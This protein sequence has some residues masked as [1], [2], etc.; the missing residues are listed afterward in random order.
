MQSKSIKQTNSKSAHTLPAVIVIITGIISGWATHAAIDATVQ[1]FSRNTIFLCIGFC[2]FYAIAFYLLDL[3]PRFIDVLIESLNLR[4]RRKLNVSA[5]F[6]FELNWQSVLTGAFIILLL[7]SPWI[8]LHHSGYL[9]SDTYNQL[10]QWLGGDTSWQQRPG[11]SDHHPVF[12]TL[13][14][15]VIFSS[16]KALT[17]QYQIG[18]VCFVI[19]KVIYMSVLYSFMLNYAHK[20]WRVCKRYTA[21]VLLVV[22][23]CPIFPTALLTVVKDSLFLLFIIPW[24]FMYIEGI[25]TKWAVLKSIPFDLAF[26]LLAVFSCLARQTS[27]IIIPVSLIAAICIRGVTPLRRIIALTAVFITLFSSVILFPALTDKPLRVVHEG[28]EQLFVVPLQL[29]ARVA[30]DHG[31]EIS[32]SDKQ[33]ITRLNSHSFEQMQKNYSPYFVDPVA[34]MR[35]N[36]STALGPYLKLWVRQGLRY[37]DSYFNGFVS[38]H[39][40]WFAYSKPPTNAIRGVG[41]HNIVPHTATLY[42]RAQKA[43][44]NTLRKGGDARK[45]LNLSEGKN[46]ETTQY[47]WDIITTIQTPLV[48]QAFWTWFL[49]MFIIY[50]LVKRRRLYKHFVGLI[51]YFL[52]LL[53]LLAMSITLSRYLFAIV[54][55]T[56]IIALFILGK[57]F[58]EESD[59][60]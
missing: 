18:F 44:A 30:Y 58:T 27:L 43:T 39:S 21:L 40:G 26:I 59:K 25:R 51:P 37:P 1:P 53:S 54:F 4:E 48:F 10:L 50:A 8:Y 57:S 49:P 11:I 12:T 14:Y 29:T 6:L 23:I 17:G 35:F 45:M 55:L 34:Q 36:D 33:L 16:S 24:V 52:S 2:I 60:E 46:I 5:R 22:G 13:I 9:A 42:R 47:L 7:W 56:P 41:M 32:H 20:H 38:L 28:S 31:N 19:F 15:G 3:A